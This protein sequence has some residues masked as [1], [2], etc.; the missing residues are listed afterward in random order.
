MKLA[1]FEQTN[2]NDSLVADFNGATEIGSVNVSKGTVY[3]NGKTQLG[4]M[5]ISGGTVQIANEVKLNG[6]SAWIYRPVGACSW[7]M[8]QFLIGPTST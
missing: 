4:T 5:T 8:A 2:A 1:G 3:L 6:S 7:P